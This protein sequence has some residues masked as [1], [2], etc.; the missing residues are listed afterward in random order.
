MF[1]KR[2]I[3]SKSQRGATL[4]DYTLLVAFVSLLCLIG[5]SSLGYRIADRECKS[6]GML[7]YAG[8]FEFEQSDFSYDA[9]SQC[10]SVLAYGGQCIPV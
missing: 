7:Q 6:V 3:K 9:E 4:I 5:V 1:A 2:H 10:C 8:N